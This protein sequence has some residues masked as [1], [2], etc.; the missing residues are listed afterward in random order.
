MIKKGAMIGAGIGASVAI[1]LITLSDIQ[2]FYM[3][4]GVIDSLTFRLCPLYILGFAKGMGSMTNV[5]IITIIGN[6]FLYGIAG[7]IIAAM[8]SL[9]KRLRFH[10]K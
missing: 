1:V 4:N 3:A 5:V 7:G 8:V 9:Y 2:P 6:A 10:A